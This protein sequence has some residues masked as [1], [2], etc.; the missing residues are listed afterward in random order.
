MVWGE[1]NHIQPVP[2]TDLYAGIEVSKWQRTDDTRWYFRHIMNINIP[3]VTEIAYCCPQ[4]YGPLDNSINIQ[5]RLDETCVNWWQIWLCM[6]PFVDVAWKTCKHCLELAWNKYA[7]VDLLCITE[8]ANHPIYFLDIQSHICMWC[9]HGIFTCNS[10]YHMLFYNI[11]Y[12]QI[13]IMKLLIF[14]VQIVIKI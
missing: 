10:C 1:V 8:N 12:A 4:K 13:K 14:M 2:Y 6:S 11:E 7:F 9:L 5:A 3:M